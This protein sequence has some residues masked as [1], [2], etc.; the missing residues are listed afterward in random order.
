MASRN[1]LAWLKRQKEDRLAIDEIDALVV[2]VTEADDAEARL[3]SLMRDLATAQATLADIR[4]TAERENGERRKRIE[5]ARDRLAKAE[6][7]A[8]TQVALRERE[9]VERLATIRQEADRQITEARTEADRQLVE[10]R[11]EIS[12]ERV[13]LS[14]IKAAR[15]AAQRDLAPFVNQQA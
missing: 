13:L 8:A 4:A 3:Q 15:E 10:I 11:A 2:A 6:A 9:C 1:A 12:R 7:D 5:D 14:E